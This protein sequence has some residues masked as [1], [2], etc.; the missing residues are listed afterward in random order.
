MRRFPTR[1]ITPLDIKKQTFERTLRGYNMEEVEAFLSMISV[2]W[3]L[4]ATT[5]REKEREL[6]MIKEQLDLQMVTQQE[7]L[8]QLEQTKSHH[9]P[10]STDLFQ[11][12]HLQRERLLMDISELEKKKTDLIYDIQKIL[13]AV[14]GALSSFNGEQALTQPDQKPEVQAPN[15]VTKH[16]N[17]TNID[18]IIDE[19]D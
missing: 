1:M 19:I 11:D 3:D 9:R 10:R 18:Y 2:E 14:S 15:N 7:L 16:S 6:T 13:F 4:M 5:L 8:D 17:P 12:G